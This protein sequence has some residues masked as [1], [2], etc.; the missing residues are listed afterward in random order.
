[1]SIQHSELE[2]RI[3]QYRLSQFLTQKDNS[4]WLNGEGLRRVFSSNSAL[5]RT[6]RFYEDS[7]VIILLDEFNDLWIRCLTSVERYEYKVPLRVDRV[8]IYQDDKLH[9]VIAPLKESEE[10]VM[11][12]ISKSDLCVRVPQHPLGIYYP[13]EIESE[14]TGLISLKEDQGNLSVDSAIDLDKSGIFY[15]KSLDFFESETLSLEEAEDLYLLP[16]GKVGDRLLRG[17]VVKVSNIESIKEVGL[18]GH[19]NSEKSHFPYPSSVYCFEQREVLTPRPSAIKRWMLDENMM[20]SIPNKVINFDSYQ[21]L[22]YQDYEICHGYI[23][24]KLKALYN[25]VFNIQKYQLDY[26]VIESVGDDLS[27]MSLFKI[28]YVYYLKKRS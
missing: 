22:E 2:K 28:P 11:T 26:L 5:Y 13:V 12:I 10:S 20:P 18:R 16:Y 23:E 25:D 8:V 9:F 14:Y 15:Q 27:V 7:E 24:G 1:M 4:I 21:Y 17:K 6:D 19:Q 3:H